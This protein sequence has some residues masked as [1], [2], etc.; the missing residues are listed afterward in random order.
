MPLVTHTVYRGDGET[1]WANAPVVFRLRP[2]SYT[3][4]GQY[5]SDVVRLRT[6]EDGTFAAE[7]WANEEG[8]S[9]SAWE[10]TLP[11]G[12]T[13][14][15]TVPASGGPFSL[16]TLRVE[17]EINRDWAGEQVTTYIGEQ[18]TAGLAPHVA[19]TDNPHEVTAAQVGALTQVA[20]DGRY[21]RSGAAN[22]INPLGNL[23]APFLQIV[24][25]STDGA[26]SSIHLTGAAG[27]AGPYL[28]GVNAQPATNVSQITSNVTRPGNK[29]YTAHL[30]NGDDAD[31]RGFVG[32]GAAGSLGRVLDLSSQGSG[33]IEYVYH[34][35]ASAA[36]NQ[37][38]IQWMSAAVS[39]QT[40]LRAYADTG[41][42]HFF[43]TLQANGGAFVVSAADGNL[44][45]NT[46]RSRI[47]SLSLGLHRYAGAGTGADAQFYAGRVRGADTTAAAV[48]LSVSSAAAK[49]GAET[50][51]E[52]LRIQRISGSACGVGFFGVNPAVRQ[53]VSGALSS[54]TDANAK[55]VLEALVGALATYGLVTDSTT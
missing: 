3:E 16:Y 47:S 4:A 55:A 21:L 43:R 51:L 31:A 6:E 22:N 2:G 52:G 26:T 19:D 45:G 40:M 53:S 42:V 44:V 49:I 24:N 37:V 27:F 11:D 38:M 35:A 9:A 50:W 10:A 5:P 36:A 48:I 15:F 34:S 41:A 23:G 30:Y 7:L 29:A 17:G 54:V 46:D 12:E 8:E 32:I 33:I 28:L 1:P 18:V 39:G 25:G 13:F 20:G 14:T